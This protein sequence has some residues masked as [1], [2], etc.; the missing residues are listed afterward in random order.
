MCGLSLTRDADLRR[1]TSEPIDYGKGRADS[2]SARPDVMAFFEA[3]WMG[4]DILFPGWLI[5]AP[6][7]SSCERV[8][9][10]HS[11]NGYCRVRIRPTSA[12]IHIE[13]A[14]VPACFLKPCNVLPLCTLAFAG[15]AHPL[16][17]SARLSMKICLNFCFDNTGATASPRYPDHR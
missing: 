17:N 1:L 10:S 14:C 2:G 3:E 5:A 6:T 12:G 16:G 4:V 7:I 15:R 11:S 8:Y 9:F 13:D